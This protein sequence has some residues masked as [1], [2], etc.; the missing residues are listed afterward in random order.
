MNRQ[1]LI[2]QILKKRSYLCVGLDSDVEKLPAGIARD[3]SGVLA[4]NK[5]I[6]D[7]TRPFCVAYKI[8]TAFYE[9]LGAAGWSVLEQTAA[10]IGHEHLL[11]A[12]AKR[13]YI[14][15]TA[16]QYARAFFKTLSF[17]AITV[18]PYMGADSVTPFLQYP[19]KWAIVLGLTSN[20]G[21]ADFELQPCGDQLLY[22]QVMQRVASWG[23]PEN[24]M[25]VVGATQASVMATIRRDYPD[26]FFLVPG[27][28]AQGGS[29]EE[30]SRNALTTDAGLLVNVSRA[31]I[32][33]S[34]N[35]DF[36]EKAEAEARLYQQQMA[37][38]MGLLL[39]L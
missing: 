31:I 7:V 32:F 36:A 2:G 11:I 20:P 27:V 14:G 38:L 23:S 15:N 28:G 21:A 29:L 37:A 17:D 12:D 26:H 34:A 19:D 35:S 8:N 39:P 22:Q 3:A 16:D 4:F 13:G 6:I 5:A 18:A 30:V 33:A 25:F 10:Y 24:L 1:A 9:S